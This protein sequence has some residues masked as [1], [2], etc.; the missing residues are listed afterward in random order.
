[1]RA[2][3]GLDAGVLMGAGR[4]S[5]RVDSVRGPHVL[6]TGLEPLQARLD[7][8]TGRAVSES[9]VLQF[10]ESLIP[11]DE[12]S[13]LAAMGQ[14]LHV[15]VDVDLEDGTRFTVDRGWFLIQE[16][17]P[18]SNGGV[19]VQAK[20]LMQR[21]K[22]DPFPFPSSPALNAGLRSELERLC[23]PYLS[24]V[25]DGVEDRGLPGG[26]AWGRSRDEAVGA[27]LSSFGLV[28]RVMEDGALHVVKPD[29]GKVLARYGSDRLVLDASVKWSRRPNHWLAVGS[30]TESVKVDDK[31]HK[32]V[33]HEWWG[34]AWAGGAFDRSLY[35]VVTETV[36]AKA[37]VD[38]Y[39]VDRLAGLSVRRFSPNGVKSFTMVPDYRVDLG[40]VI[41]VGLSDGSVFVG[42]VSGF[43]MPLDG[44][45]STMRLDVEGVV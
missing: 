8:S 43:S 20:G 33:K 18:R 22:D 26:L 25:L 14:T 7:V 19:S 28:G 11:V 45:T 1:M 44:G 3:H 10:D 27:L 23:Y 37:A 13:P 32:S 2:P 39:D 29:A 5:T 6:A 30:K 12:W 35:G 34:E 38:Q 42:S 16:V 40:D 24:V 41:S 31:H 17:E 36:E 4:V 9:L 15:F 21:L